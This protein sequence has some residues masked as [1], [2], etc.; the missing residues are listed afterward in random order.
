MSMQM[1]SFV[2]VPRCFLTSSFRRSF[3]DDDAKVQVVEGAAS[4]V[5]LVIVGLS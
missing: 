3:E 5:V 2:Y 4:V 1:T